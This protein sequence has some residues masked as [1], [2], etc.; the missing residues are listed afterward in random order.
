MKFCINNKY[1][2][3]LSLISI[4]AICF[5]MISLGSAAKSTYYDNPSHS[6]QERNNTLNYGI[7]SIV[8]TFAYKDPARIISEDANSMTVLA[9][10]SS[11]WDDWQ[12]RAYYVKW[13]KTVWIDQINGDNCQDTTPVTTANIEF[14]PKGTAEGELTAVWSADWKHDGCDF[15]A[16][17]GFEKETS[18]THL[19]IWK[20]RGSYPV[21]A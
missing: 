13:P 5:S 16:I 18:W 4:F 21:A 19:S 14:N 7:P 17:T 6:A 9:Y 12:F 15:S 20:S 10:P 11:Y 3:L 1:I 8:A 2:K